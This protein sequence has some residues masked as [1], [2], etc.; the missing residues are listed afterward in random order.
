MN[1][2]ALD[3]LFRPKSVALIGASTDP[4]KIGGRPL[5]FLK[6]HGFTG[7]IWPI[8]PKAE[9]IEGLP[10]FTDIASLPG[11]PD[12][13]IVLLGPRHVEPALKD[14]ALRKTGA[15]N[16][17]AGGFA[18]TGDDGVARQVADE[19]HHGLVLDERAG[20]R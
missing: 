1:R 5:H 18:E 7:D 16:V 14:L 4:K 19:G 3:R 9:E 2:S 8:N 10:C 17:L 12:L 6:K 15:A 11:T 20:L 13:A